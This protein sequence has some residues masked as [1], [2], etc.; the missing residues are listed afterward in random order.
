MNKESILTMINELPEDA[1]G[2]H[3]VVAAAYEIA[4]LKTESE[5]IPLIEKLAKKNRVKN[6]LIVQEVRAFSTHTGIKKTAKELKG[7]YLVNKDGYLYTFNT[8]SGD[9]QCL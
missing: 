8:T 7:K 2:S 3:L 6:R 1:K 5:R 4:Q 9:E